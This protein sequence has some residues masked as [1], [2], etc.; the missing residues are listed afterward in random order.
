MPY[1]IWSI[2]ASRTRGRLSAIGSTT[3]LSQSRVRRIAA[4]LFPSRV[5]QHVTSHS[6]KGPIARGTVRT[7]FVLGL[8]LLV[9]AGTLLL[10]ARM[11]GP[12]QFGAFAG[13]AALAVLLGTLAPFGTHIVLLGEVAKNPARRNP[14]LAYAIPTTLLCGA[15]L[16]VI[17]L[18]VCLLVLRIPGAPW[19]V[20][21]AIGITELWLQPLLNLAVY[22]RQGLGRIARSQLLKT[23][24]LAF[25]LVTAACIFVTQ[26]GTPLI[27]YAYAYP[28][29]SLLALVLT[30]RFFSSSWP[31]P[32]QW[33]LPRTAELREASGYAAVAITASGPGEL[34]KTLAT[35]L[36]TLPAAGVYAVGAR[37]VVV[38]TLPINA[39]LAA[40]L[41]RLFRD[42]H[43]ESGGARR[44]LFWLFGAGIVYV[45][46]ITTILWF[47]APAAEWVFGAKYHELGHMIRWLCL[48]VPGLALRMIAGTVMMALGRPWAR[49]GFEATGLIALAVASI[50][51]TERFGAVGMPLALA[52]SEWAMAAIGMTL[53]LRYTTRPSA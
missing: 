44:L 42:S 22:E 3:T 50:M 49:V 21:L 52:G 17:Y 10:V 51:L 40:A 23:L 43:D 6:M 37:A 53:I 33:R 45:I 32:N 19:A 26:I 35:K 18:T 12:H 34:D 28:V 41:P 9:Q 16:L 30:I 7:T 14:V 27:A 47:V 46:A 11:L 2:E 15:A 29:L 24:P 13:I 39:M 8:Y 25:R 31:G 20:L 36:L 38:A 48:A 4:A 5:R 1:A